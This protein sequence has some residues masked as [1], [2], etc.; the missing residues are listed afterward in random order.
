MFTAKLFNRFTAVSKKTGN[1]FY[2]VDLLVDTPSG[3]RVVMKSFV[4]ED[5]Y[6]KCIN[7]PL[8][9]VVTV[10][11]G[12]NNYGNLCIKDIIASK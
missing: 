7:T 5:V 12:V 2:S 8:D 1:P 9:S 4:D 11:A 6:N 10:K 3:N